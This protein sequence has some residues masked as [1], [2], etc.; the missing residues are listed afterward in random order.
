MDA[1]F[2][3]Q[4][5]LA[6]FTFGLLAIA[7]SNLRAW[8]R[9]E[10]YGPPAGLP[11]ASILLPARDEEDNIEACVR[12]LLAQDYPD[13]EVIALDDDSSD[14]T[15]RILSELAEASDR[16]RVLAGKPLPGDW[17]GKHWACH[18]LAQAAT[19]EL[20]LFT[21]ADTRH[22]PLALRDAVAALQAERADLLTALPRQIVGSWAERLIVPIIPW[23]LFALVPLALAHRLR[24]TSLVVA[25][26]Q[27]L[28]IRREAYERSGGH[29]AVRRSAVDDI[30][31][32]RR[33]VSHGLCW[34]LVDGGGR[35]ECRMYRDAR[36]VIEGLSK[37]LYAAFD[38]R[39][40]QFVFVWTW[41]SIVFVAWPILL[42]LGALGITLPGFAPD[43][44]AVAVAASFALW[45]L[46]CRRF[47]F[48]SVLAMLYPISMALAVVIAF[49]SMALTLT[50]R[51]TWRGRAL[52]TRGAIGVKRQT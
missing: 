22:H 13:F 50:G 11:R 47:G 20:L 31:L 21:D 18:Q 32:A 12:S 37:N 49:R 4:V 25:V 17:L 2:N 34:R 5:G 33:I 44:A 43:W 46:V 52:V 8:Q 29:A 36:Q 45:L 41:L 48:P 16:L 35:I 14:G 7:L 26:G 9:L 23:S 10:Q 1:W 27:Y 39:L 28:L 19:G 30:A 40:P 38:Y 51:A 6:F 15:G 24:R 3:F 42:A